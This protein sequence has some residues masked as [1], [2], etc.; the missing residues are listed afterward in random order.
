MPTLKK[1]RAMM[2]MNKWRLRR[3]STLDE[4]KTDVSFLYPPPNGGWGWVVVL[5]AATHCLLVSGF[6]SAFGVYMLPLLDT[7]KSSN[8][9]IGRSLL[10]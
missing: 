5:A 2:H 10:H 4:I 8:S 9:Q 3:T 1:I 7:F 6:H